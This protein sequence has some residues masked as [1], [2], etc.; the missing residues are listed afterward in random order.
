MNIKQ[1]LQLASLTLS[2]FL[3]GCSGAV[4]APEPA[5]PGPV[6]T[7]PAQADVAASLCALL[8]PGIAYED[9]P[10]LGPDFSGSSLKVLRVRSGSRLQYAT[11]PRPIDLPSGEGVLQLAYGFDVNDELQLEVCLKGSDGHATHSA[12]I[13]SQGGQHP[14]VTRIFVAN[15]DANPAGE[16]IVLV[17]WKVENALGSVGTMYEP[18]VFKIEDGRTLMQRVELA[19]PSLSFGFDGIREGE[20]VEYPFA[21]ERA[22]RTRLQELGY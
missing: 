14:E 10:A 1:T 17:A 21:D 20:K 15:A 16:L 6:A 13:G 11:R 5:K 7:A 12:A 2:A 3:A 4:P 22:F 18:H 8:G 9:V 19:D